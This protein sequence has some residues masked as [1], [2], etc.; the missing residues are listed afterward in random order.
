MVEPPPSPMV[1]QPVTTV[2]AVKIRNCRRVMHAPMSS[3]SVMVSILE[4]QARDNT[5]VHFFAGPV[6]DW[7]NVSDTQSRLDR[8]DGLE[9]NAYGCISGEDVVSG[10]SIIQLRFS[11]QFKYG[12]ELQYVWQWQLLVRD[13]VAKSEAVFERLQS[14]FVTVT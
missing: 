3:E 7:E 2:A 14:S 1:W 10:I 5:P 9:V 11:A 12:D 4:Y 13:G 6:V 8:A